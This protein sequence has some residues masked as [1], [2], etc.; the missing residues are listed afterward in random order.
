M[1]IQIPATMNARGRLFCFY[2]YVDPL[3]FLLEARLRKRGLVPGVD[4]L[5]LPFEVNPPPHAL[6]DAEDTEWETRWNRA[7][8]AAPRMGLPG[9]APWIV[10][11]TRKAHELVFHAAEENSPGEIHEALFRAY[12]ID[13]RDIG[14][15]DV[16]VD[17]ARETGLDPTRAKAAL[18]VDKHTGALEVIRS[19]ATQEGVQG[20]PTLL[21]GGKLLSGYPTPE[22][23][24]EFLATGDPGSNNLNR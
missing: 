20:P 6:L 5:P 14:R 8:E 10:P 24:D 1:R 23:L 16:L 4:L 11:W 7:V 21:L 3:S 15:V 22:A 17:L 18:D 2:D 12:L 13:G 9:K 19:R